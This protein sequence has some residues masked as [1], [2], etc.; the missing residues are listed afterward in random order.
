MFSSRIQAHPDP[1]EVANYLMNV[2][3]VAAKR[4]ESK[5]IDCENK[6]KCKAADADVIC[7]FFICICKIE[8]NFYAVKNF[9]RITKKLKVQEESRAS[10]SQDESKCD[11]PLLKSKGTSSGSD[12]T[13]SPCSDYCNILGLSFISSMLWVN[14]ILA[15][16]LLTE[17]NS[18]V[19]VDV[20]DEILGGEVASFV[21]SFKS[22]RTLVHKYGIDYPRPVGTKRLGSELSTTE[23]TASN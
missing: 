13:S 11:S 14:F 9:G 12:N 1:V 17:M 23:E 21:S 8:I 2:E 16:S 5:F 10:S 22:A 6:R 18:D 15:R 19:G 3:N 4:H 20:I 7:W